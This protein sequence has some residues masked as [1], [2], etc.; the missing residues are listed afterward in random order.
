[1]ENDNKINNSQENS[2]VNNINDNQV[3]DYCFKTFY[4]KNIIDLFSKHTIMDLLK[5]VLFFLIFTVIFTLLCIFDYSVF[6][7]ICLIFF[8]LIVLFFFIILLS[9]IGGKKKMYSQPLFESTSNV[10]IYPDHL[11]ISNVGKTSESTENIPFEKITRF[12]E[13][14]DL[15]MLTTDTNQNYIFSKSQINDIEVESYLKNRLYDYVIYFNNKQ[16]RKIKKSE[17]KKK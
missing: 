4:D 3:K 9:M 10:T 8:A 2:N 17:K 15:L 16:I 14:K 13:Y 12:L 1:M 6:F 7:L 5:I 11:F